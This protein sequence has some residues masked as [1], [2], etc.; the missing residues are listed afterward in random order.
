M[1]KE[2]SKLLTKILLKLFLKYLMTSSSPLTKPFLTPILANDSL[3]PTFT[4]FVI[5][6]NLSL[7]SLF[8]IAPVLCKRILSP[9]SS[10]FK[11]SKRNFLAGLEFYR[12]LPGHF[13]PTSL[14]VSPQKSC[15]TSFSNLLS[16]L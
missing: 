7:P 3:K 2:P 13:A 1:I 16:T 5:P 8:K 6:A 12:S 15:K 4:S 11:E 14:S 9:K 10:T